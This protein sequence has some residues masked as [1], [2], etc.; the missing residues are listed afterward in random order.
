MSDLNGKQ[1][2]S[3]RR[4]LMGTAAVTGTFLVACGTPSTPASK[5]AESTA[6][7]VQPAAEA[8]SAP[9]AS[10]PAPTEAAPTAAPAVAGEPLALEWYSVFGAW[11]E[12]GLK[13]ATD[14]Y[15]KENPNITV[16]FFW[17][18]DTSQGA[19]EGLLARIAAGNPPD[20][21][22]MWDSP[23]ALGV[24]GA[25]MP[26]DELMAASKVSAEG[27]WPAALFRDCKWQGKAY[28]LPSFCAVYCLWYNTELMERNGMPATRDDLPKTWDELQALSKEFVQYENGTYKSI[29][30]FPLWNYHPE[31]W[32]QNNGGGSYDDAKIKY[33]IDSPQ[34]ID[35]FDYAVKWSDAQYPG[36]MEA[37]KGTGW[38]MWDDLG[39]EPAF[40]DGRIF[41]EYGGNFSA[42]MY[43]GETP[44]Q[45]KWEIATLPRGPQGTKNFSTTWPNWISLPK[46]AKHPN[47]TFAFVDWFNGEGVRYWCTA[48]NSDMPGNK[49]F[50][51]NF[52][53]PIISKARGEE[54]AR[55][56]QK[57]FVEQLDRNADMYLSPVSTFQYDQLQRIGERILK[58]VTTPAEGLKEAQAACQAELD[59]VL[60]QNA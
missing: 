15:T 11:G 10:T 41:A 23:V 40:Q 60:A 39:G 7:P 6:A 53:S 5:P 20:M 16:K 33:T 59:K 27:N 35:T 18:G 22:V 52:I 24:R 47:E 1:R 31:A 50:D 57:F 13:A 56:W 2:I 37:V 43:N 46:G 17:G 12:P 21:E 19:L 4:F 26:L 51:P 54:Y 3:R 42:G 45:L 49:K 44:P 29:G 25:L 48:G 58:K 14:V 38:D 34:N 28:G 30:Y 9:A 55:S 32:F 8:T 36:G